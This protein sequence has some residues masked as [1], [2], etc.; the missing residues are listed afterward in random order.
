MEN[1]KPTLSKGNYRSIEQEIKK[2]K[3]R[4]EE[5]ILRVLAYFEPEIN[6]LC[7]YIKISKEDAAQHIKLEL[8]EYLFLDTNNFS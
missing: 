4:D 5:A 3:E 6:E 2:A 7:K 1:K 8:L